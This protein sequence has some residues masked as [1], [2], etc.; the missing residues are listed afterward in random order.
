M[1]DNYGGE[2]KTQDLGLT[3]LQNSAKDFYRAKPGHNED[4]CTAMASDATYTAAM[5][6]T[7]APATINDIKGSERDKWRGGATASWTE[8]ANKIIIV[9]S[10]LS[11][12][13]AHPARPML[14]DTAA[15][16]RPRSPG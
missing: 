3:L 1:L 7:R 10:T 13:S 14:K 11:V 8:G 12:S 5:K 15:P 2:L 9:N 6:T 16:I 4:T